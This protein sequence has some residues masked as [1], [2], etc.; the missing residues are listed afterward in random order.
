MWVDYSS[1]VQSI[2]D[3]LSTELSKNGWNNFLKYRI[4]NGF[5]FGEVRLFKSL[6]SDLQTRF[7]GIVYGYNTSN[8]LFNDNR[9]IFNDSPL[10]LVGLGDGVKTDF[11]LKLYP[12]DTSIF[13]LYKNGVE[14]KS[15]D[16]T[17]E[18]ERGR[19][20]FSVA[21]EL[22]SLITVTYKLG[23]SA[24]EPPT[25]LIFFT[26][27]NIF[28][29]NQSLIQDGGSP[30]SIG[31]GNG[32]TTK[33]LIP[34]TPIKP[35]SLTVYLNGVTTSN[36]TIDYT[37]GEVTFN[38]APLSQ[39]EITAKYLILFN[40]ELDVT[41]GTG[42]GEETEFSVPIKP[43]KEDSLLEVTVGGL[44]KE[45]DTDYTV[46][47]VEGIIDFENAPGTGQKIDVIYTTTIYNS[48][49][50]GDFSVTIPDISSATFDGLN[51]QSLMGAVYNSLNYSFP[52]LPTVVSFT[53]ETNF[54][55]GW[56]RD[57]S[58]YFWGN[59]NK[60][61]MIL[62]IRPDPA[63]GAE[64]AYFS[65]LYAGR[66]QTIGKSPR[67]NMVL[68]GG[69][70]DTDEI[71]WSA[72]K[73]LGN[74]IVDYGPGTSNGNSSPLLQQSIGGAYYQT[75]YFAFITHDKAID[76]GEGRYNPSV[77]SGKYHLSEIYLV[78]PND[79]Y[80]GKL[81][82]VFAMHPKNVYQNNE[83]EIQ[84]DV[85]LYQVGTGD[86]INKIFHVPHAPTGGK[87]GLVV[88][89]NSEDEC[90]ETTGFVYDEETKTITL[91]TAAVNK[92]II[93]VSYSYNHVYKFVLPTTPRTP[94][95]IDGITPY[96]PIG[97]AVFKEKDPVE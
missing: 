96:N 70:K 94:Y 37:L 22:N 50:I 48:T 23:S 88:T 65:T 62:F 39:V 86:G 7:L 27:N 71:L 11:Q 46:N 45:I 40:S 51:T 9:I 57:S 61:R 3:D 82:D 49:S 24:P 68:I 92:A 43:I 58:I 60:D 18:K 33:F 93:L 31:T 59:I 83:F 4:K 15:T 54:G 25:K 36:Y 76:S 95:R 77:Y 17:L 72:N 21:P 16:Y 64:L 85:S 79:G 12:V 42:D 74:S 78:H 69:C 97:L 41:I 1:Y 52:S 35:D 13:T 38:T 2:V 14:I 63:V 90:I 6:G 30:V 75:H 29:E 91:N 80:V 87:E 28:L 67:K 53:S 32:T 19:I 56:Q 73:K 10:G 8:S 34:N 84:E 55:R 66:L 26:F 44:L 47:Y 81:D 89:I 5:N 20:R